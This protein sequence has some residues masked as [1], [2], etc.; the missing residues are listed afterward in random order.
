MRG[1]LFAVFFCA[2]SLLFAEALTTFLIRLSFVHL[3]E[4]DDIHSLI[5]II[6]LVVYMVVAPIFIK[7]S[8]HHNNEDDMKM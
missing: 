1:L 8:K 3:N 2:V 4:F 7:Y 5:M 6:M